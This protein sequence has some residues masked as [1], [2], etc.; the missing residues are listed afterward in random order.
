MTSPLRMTKRTEAPL[1]RHSETV[2]SMAPGT[3][4][5]LSRIKVG[6]P[7]LDFV[8]AH[9]GDHPPPAHGLE[10]HGFGD[11]ASLRR[12][13]TR[14][15]SPAG[16]PNPPRRL[17]PNRAC[18]CRH[19][20]QP[21]WSVTRCSPLVNVPVLSNRTTS[22][23]RIRSSANRSLT[24]IPLRAAFPV[25][26]AT[27]KGIGQAQCV[28]TCD[29]QHRYRSHHGL[30]GPARDR[31][32]HHGKGGSTHCHI[33]QQ[34]GGTIGENLG[35]RSRSLCIGDQALDAGERGGRRRRRSPPL[36]S[37]SPWQ[38]SPQPPCL[39]ALGILVS[40]RR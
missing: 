34:R 19:R 17:P 5:P 25:E 10:P 24:R 30:V 4:A 3:A 11:L 28:R 37:P 22:T 32:G 12:G 23:V 2:S 27:T 7:N 20:R 38:R 26:M 18:A 33:E 40:T 14:S 15:P 21:P 29:Y 9:P 39:R 36:G 1:S 6:P 13:P 8:T 16:A 31:P 35:V